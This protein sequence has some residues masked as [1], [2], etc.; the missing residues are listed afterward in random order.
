MT[1]K[2]RKLMGLRLMLAEVEITADNKR[3]EIE[4]LEARADMLKADIKL[5]LFKDVAGYGP[6]D[7]PSVPK[8]SAY[9]SDAAGSA[10]FNEACDKWSRYS[11]LVADEFPLWLDHF[12]DPAESDAMTGVE[13]VGVADS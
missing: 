3:R 9:T 10:A 8:R 6:D 7:V 1:V 13:P 5:E 11:K 2:N 12:S 4:R